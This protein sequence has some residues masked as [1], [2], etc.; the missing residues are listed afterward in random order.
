[1]YALPKGNTKEILAKTRR[2]ISQKYES[3]GNQ[4]VSKNKRD[5][6]HLPVNEISTCKPIFHNNRT[7]K[8]C[9]SK[10]VEEITPQHLE[11]I[12]YVREGWLI[13]LRDF[14]NSNKTNCSNNDMATNGTNNYTS[15]QNQNQSTPKVSYYKNRSASVPKFEPFDLETFWGQRLYQNLTR[16]T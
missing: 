8:I 6:D 10:D 3:F 11:M 4:K 12:K 13:V 9:I 5:S 16:S 15:N 2:G 1:M 14:E 7:K